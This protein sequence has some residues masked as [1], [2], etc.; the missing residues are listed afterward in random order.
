MSDLKA[1]ETKALDLLHDLLARA[2]AGG[3]DAADA[4]LFESVSLGASCRLGKPEDLERAESRDLGLRVLVGKRQAFV[5]S[6]D[7]APAMRAELVERALAMARLAPEDPHCGLADPALLAKDLAD[8]DL[9][10]TAEPDGD[11]LVATARLAEDAGRAVKGVTNSEGGQAGWGHASVALATSGGYSGAYSSTSHS[12]SCSV[13]AGS[14]GGMERDY[15]YSAARHL[16][17]LEDAAEIGR[18]AGERAVKRLNPRKVKSAQ[19]PVVYDPRVSNG[20]VRHFAT[21]I[22]GQAVARGTSFLKDAMGTQV[23]ADGITITD[24][25]HRPRGLRSKPVDGEG[26]AN[27]PY[28]LVADGRL[29]TW[30]LDTASASQLGLASTGHAARGTASPPSPATT[31]LYMAAGDVSPQAMI[32]DIEEGFYVTELI[33]FGISMVTGDYSRGAAGF[34]IE[35]GEIAYPVSELTVAGNLADMFRNLTPADDLVF[36]YGTDAPT[37]RVD[38]LTV[39]GA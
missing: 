34:W 29:T 4:V 9:S 18:R 28:D 36:R 15:D 20:L 2:K 1:A 31:N 8:L 21:A 3:A 10:D 14:D 5:S 39:A 13:I 17:D 26:V 19:I 6:N 35:N 11:A 16:A 25:P 12:V 30:M 33:G 22:N 23:F 37:I 32:A 38:G 7:W 24:D 27:R